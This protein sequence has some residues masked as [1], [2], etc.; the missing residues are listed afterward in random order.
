MYLCNK[1]VVFPFS[2]IYLIGFWNCTEN[3][4]FSVYH[5]IFRIS[6]YGQTRTYNWNSK[7]SRSDKVL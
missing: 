3:V 5:F 6:L 2:T 4:I 7:S 1:S